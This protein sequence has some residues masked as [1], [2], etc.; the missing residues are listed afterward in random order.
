MVGSLTFSAYWM[1]RMIR[2]VISAEGKGQK[3]PSLLIF[4]GGI[5]FLGRHGRAVPDGGA[6][7]LVFLLLIP[8]NFMLVGLF[9]ILGRN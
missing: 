6:T 4:G 8:L 9:L 1:V 3:F 2:E 7:R 5:Y